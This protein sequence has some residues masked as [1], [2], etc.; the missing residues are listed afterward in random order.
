M[1]WIARKSNSVTDYPKMRSEKDM[2]EPFPILDRQSTSQYQLTVHNQQLIINP[3][4]DHHLT[5]TNHQAALAL[6]LFGRLL[7]TI[8]TH[9]IPLITIIHHQSKPFINHPLTAPPRPGIPT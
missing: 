4:Q 9:Y 1:V 8:V 3:P 5:I 6:T 7:T 2:F